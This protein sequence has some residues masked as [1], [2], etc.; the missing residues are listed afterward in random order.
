MQFILEATSPEDRSFISKLVEEFHSRQIC[1]APCLD[2]KWTTDDGTAMLYLIDR[3]AG[4][5][6]EGNSLAICVGDHKYRISVSWGFV[7]PFG[8]NK[9]HAR[10]YIYCREMLLDGLSVDLL[11]LAGAAIF[12][13]CEYQR[14][15]W[16]TDTPF[17]GV[18]ITFQ[19]TGKYSNAA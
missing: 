7:G 3:L 8:T 11:E 1:S 13:S 6:W 9:Y 15:M 4:P 19:P 2:V 14:S 12:A 10:A 16:G 17:G 5:G 18:E